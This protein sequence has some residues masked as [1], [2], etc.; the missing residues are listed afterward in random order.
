MF[1]F[2]KKVCTNA[3][4]F[5]TI[6]KATTNRQREARELARESDLMLVI[7]GRH[8][9]NTAKLKEVCEPYAQTYLIETAAELAALPV[10]GKM[11]IGITAR[12]FN[13]GKHN[14]GGTCYH[15]RQN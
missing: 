14:K 3:S 1:G 7:G 4:V 11:N 2:V 10:K 6:C 8:S 5:D 13:T 15:D 12:C 9:S